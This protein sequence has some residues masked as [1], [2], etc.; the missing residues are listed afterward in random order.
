MV[1][2]RVGAPDN[3]SRFFVIPPAPMFWL[4]GLEMWF[5]TRPLR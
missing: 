3:L 5:V 4:S 2:W 1:A